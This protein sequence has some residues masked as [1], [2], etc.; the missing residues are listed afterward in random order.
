MNHIIQDLLLKPNY[1]FYRHLLVQI[2][3][4]LITSNI[5]WDEPNKILP[6]R[7]CVWIVYFLL[8]NSIIYINIYLLVPHLL[9]KGKTLYYILSLPILM[10]CFGFILSSIQ[11]LVSTSL[12]NSNQN[13]LESTLG[14]ISSISA[15]CFLIAGLTVFHLLKNKLENTKKINELQKASM[16]VELAN[17]KNQ[18]NPHFLFNMLNNANILAGEDIYKSSYVLSKLN[19]LLRYQI[20]SSTK[21]S[22][23]LND[24]INFI[25]DFLELEKTRR[26]KFHYTIHKDGDY[27]IEI[28]PLLLIPFVEN[29]VKHNPENNSHIN[30]HF[31]IKENQLYFK[32][33][34]NK[35]SLIHK[36]KDG[37]IGLIN[38]KKRLELLFGKNYRLELLDEKNNYT[39]IMK[40]KL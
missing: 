15:F 26:D 30:I 2:I 17:L 35:P 24:D 32:C 12:D 27:N 5:F 20:E 18:I 1:R 3:V 28:P 23:L 19:D 37:G 10:I 25:N 9:L 31:Q 38:I 22:V 16:E 4:L 11:D 7:F 36:R 29:A 21:E 14:T 39:V 8:I 34:N 13:S 33:E 6:E 40:F